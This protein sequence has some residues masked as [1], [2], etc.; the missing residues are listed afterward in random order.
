VID[1][2]N[3]DSTLD[4]GTLLCSGS[5]IDL[6]KQDSP[7]VPGYE[8]VGPIDSGSFGE[9]W[10][11]VH[12][13]TGQEVAIKFFS[14]EGGRRQ[15]QEIDRLRESSRHP[16]IVTLLDANTESDPPFL[17]M[18][19]YSENLKARL[20]G[21]TPVP[22]AVKW[23]HQLADAVRHIHQA[24]TV[25]CDLKPANLLLDDKAVLHVADFGQASRIGS[26]GLRGTF[27][28]M[29]PEQASARPSQP[30]PSWDVY[31]FG[32]VAYTL[33]T[34]RLPR[35][36]LKVDGPAIDA[37][38]TS[39]QKL[40]LYRDL[41]YQCE[42]E[43]PSSLRA[44]VDPKLDALVMACLQLKPELR[45]AGMADIV[46][47]LERRRDGLP[48]LC[49]K[50]RSLG[51]R[52]RSV[53]TN[54]EAE[55]LSMAAVFGEWSRVR[56]NERQLTS[57][58]LLD[59]GKK[60][61]DS[62]EPLAAFD[63]LSRVGSLANQA[64][65]QQMF[66]LALARCGDWR[67][68]REVLV[69]LRD[70]GKKDSET[71]GLLAR[72]Y[73][74]EWLEIGRRQ[75]LEKCHRI[76]YDAYQRAKE[77]ED[78]GG[79]IYTGVNAATTGILLG[80]IEESRQIA[81]E[82]LVQCSGKKDYWSACTLGECYLILMNWDAAA[83]QYQRAAELAGDDYGKIATTRRQA[84]LLLQHLGQPS[85]LLDG[86]LVV[87]RVFQADQTGLDYTALNESV[88][89]EMSSEKQ[90]IFSICL[91]SQHDVHLVDTLT[92]CDPEL[93]LVLPLPSSEFLERCVQD[94]DLKIT[95]RQL[96]DRASRVV[97]VGVS[98]EPLD[99]K[100]R[101][102][103][104]SVSRGLGALRA[105]SLCSSVSKISPFSKPVSGS[106]DTQDSS[107]ERVLSAYLYIHLGGLSSAK[108]AEIHNLV[109]GVLGAVLRVTEGNTPPRSMKE[110]LDGYLLIYES[111]ADAAEVGCEIAEA[112][113]LD[114]P[115]T[116]AR[117]ILHCGPAFAIEDPSTGRMNCYGNHVSWVA[118]IEPVTPCFQVYATH[119]FAAWLLDF[120]KGAFTI[121][122]VGEAPLK[123]RTEQLPLFCIRRDHLKRESI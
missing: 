29:S 57:T 86:L 5:A 28:F 77:T 23:L 81:S 42:L 70:A 40:R 88:M 43:P 103:A 114:F 111:P 119:S 78:V 45:P 93:Q 46:E 121:E 54:S 83:E 7:V 10:R 16:N 82:L 92:D 36:D 76:Y 3:E 84:K 104:L 55:G 110:Q 25:H 17:V 30:N 58:Q 109:C 37:A 72:T 51:Y 63:V 34:G 113:R 91:L 33:L 73:K 80:E 68:A 1:Q 19:H 87:P 62:G 67:A 65:N 74:D 97:S 98:G 11:G 47:D 26:S 52:T 41:L 106:F 4:D 69:K 123:N 14:A 56:R 64:E 107:P 115:Q 102:F 112:L 95:G 53:H 8:M 27:G 15:V 22:T 38:T 39:T 108:E 18:L 105:R 44:E 9:V 2:S 101:D 6:I 122:Y 71:C 50:P 32:A 99:Q 94:P 90:V 116:A 118:Q 75:T 49:T 85:E 20:G 35:F 117:F 13:A 79:A 21:S 31:A 89:A 61:L 120:D 100:L 96:L 60:M 48:L 59:L 66:A 24:G 12:L